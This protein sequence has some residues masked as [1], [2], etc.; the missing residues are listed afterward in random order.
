MLRFLIVVLCLLAVLAVTYPVL[1]GAVLERPLEVLLSEMFGMRVEIDRLRADPVSGEVKAG[2]IVFQNQPGFSPGPHFDTALE[3]RIRFW[4]LTRKK[5]ILDRVVLTHAYYFIHRIHTPE[6]PDN[7]ASMWIRHIR[8]W[9]QDRDTDPG[10]PTK[11]TVSIDS[12]LIR[13][14]AFVC[15]ETRPDGL[16]LRLFFRQLEGEWKNFFWRS[17]DPG[18]LPETIRLKGL[19]GEINPAPFTIDGQT[20]FAASE[21]NF[22][23]RGIVPDGDITEYTQL[24]EGL[25][26]KIGGGRYSL[27]VRAVCRRERLKAENV[28]VLKDLKV[29]PEL[30]L[31]GTL[32]GLP[33]VAGAAF[34]QKEKMIRLTVPVEGDLDN[35]KFRV[36]GAFKTAFQDSLRG[37]MQRGMNLLTAAPAEIVKRTQEFAQQAPAEIVGG[38]EKLSSLL[39]GGAAQVKG[40]IKGE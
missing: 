35:P 26:L 24:W 27:D 1:I 13:D 3:G 11:W 30:S 10:T 15:E 25:P 33:L 39:T 36:V 14:G 40:K 21:I 9:K 5:V 34:L 17:R 12:L 18:G 31:G 16:G 23:L 4:D 6:G 29:N 22:D 7:N 2:R 37:Y 20:N 8:K 19:F 28:V 32:W 38:V